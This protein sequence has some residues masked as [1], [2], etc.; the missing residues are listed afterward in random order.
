MSATDWTPPHD[1]LGAFCR[2]NHVVLISP[3]QGTAIDRARLRWSTNDLGDFC[4][5]G[6]G[7]FGTRHDPGSQDFDLPCPSKPGKESRLHGPAS[8]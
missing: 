3:L 6:S 4:R 7:R 5:C 2:D 8:C 1:P